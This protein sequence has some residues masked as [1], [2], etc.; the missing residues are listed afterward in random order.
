MNLD[1]VSVREDIAYERRRI[2][3]A[4]RAP[5]E[6]RVVDETALAAAQRRRR[7]RIV[8]LEAHEEVLVALEE[9]AAELRE[10]FDLDFATGHPMD[11]MASQE[12]RRAALEPRYAAA[13]RSF[14][15]GE[16]A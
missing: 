5:V 13:V 14:Y 10:S 9:S 7:E 4:D 8:E 12:E 15:G 2:E 11:R 16:A 6:G 3:Q 1:L